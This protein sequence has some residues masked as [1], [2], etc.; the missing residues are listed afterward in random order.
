MRYIYSN[1]VTDRPGIA[2][3]EYTVLAMGINL[4]IIVAVNGLG[5]V[6]DTAFSSVNPLLESV[7]TRFC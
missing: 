1:S 5:K 7:C 3:I 2:A 4:A 6:L